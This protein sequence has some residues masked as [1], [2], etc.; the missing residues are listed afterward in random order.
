MTLE[1][2]LLGHPWPPVGHRLCVTW[3]RCELQFPFNGRGNIKEPLLK[4]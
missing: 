2:Y 4:V 1:W 3:E